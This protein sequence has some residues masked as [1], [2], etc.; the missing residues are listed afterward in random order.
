MGFRWGGGPRTRRGSNWKRC[1]SQRPGSQLGEG[2]KAVSWVA[3]ISEWLEWGW[4]LR[5]KAAQ[6]G[7][8]A[9]AK[10]VQMVGSG[11]KQGSN[12]AAWVWWPWWGAA[13]LL[14]TGLMGFKFCV[15]RLCSHPGAGVGWGGRAQRTRFHLPSPG[16]VWGWILTFPGAPMASV[17]STR[18]PAAA[19]SPTAASTA[20]PTTP[21]LF[22]PHPPTPRGWAACACA[23]PSSRPALPTKAFSTRSPVRMR[24]RQWVGGVGWGRFL[25]PASFPSLSTPP[26]PRH[27]PGT[28]ARA[29]CIAVPTHPSHTLSPPTFA[30]CFSALPSPLPQLLR[31]GLEYTEPCFPSMNDP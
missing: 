26:P 24:F 31:C 14:T 15:L 9:S 10:G 18:N 29:P 13:P 7:A 28:R 12:R 30:Q 22:S 17:L 11:V 2:G 25:P 8:H 27:R 21:P 23:D 3:P 19:P 1:R 20:A 5:A 6:H 4:G 16:P